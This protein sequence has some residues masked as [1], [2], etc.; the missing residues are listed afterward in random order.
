MQ[1]LLHPTQTVRHFPKPADV[2]VVVAARLS[3]SF[4]GLISAVPLHFVDYG[5]RPESIA[6]VTAWFSDGGIASNFPMHLFDDA[7]PTRPTFGFDLQPSSVDHG[8]AKVIIPRRVGGGRSHPIGNVVGFGKAILDTMQNWS[9]NTQ[10]GMNTF[11]DRVPEVRLDA[12]EGGINLAMPAPVIETIADRGGEAAALLDDFDLAAHQDARA[13]MALR[14]LDGLFE[15]LRQS[16]ADGFG[17]TLDQL[18]SNR[19]AAAHDL[20]QLVDSWAAQHPLSSGESPQLQ[21]DMRA[22]PRQ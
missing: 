18:N 13:K 1:C 10:L 17:L 6:L 11:G 4:P 19:R 12:S 3:L 7:F 14:L 5:R 20:L 16:C 22:A 21:A 9:D 8:S 15:S 2:P